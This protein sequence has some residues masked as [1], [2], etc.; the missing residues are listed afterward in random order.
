MYIII[1][2]IPAAWNHEVHFY[3]KVHDGLLI[4]VEVSLVTSGVQL[5]A[6]H[7]IKYC[8]SNIIVDWSR[9]IKIN[10]GTVIQT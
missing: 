4:A 10:T 7:K 9:P 6:E 2:L 3:F 1:L 8:Y 5:R